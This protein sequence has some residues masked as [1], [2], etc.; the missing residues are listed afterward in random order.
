M[1]PLR[2]IKIPEK[3]PT[4]IEGIEHITQGGFTKGRTTLVVGTS[5]S[6]KTL[7]SLEFLYRGIT[8]FQQKAVFVTIEEEVEDII[9]N[10]KNLGWDLDTLEQ[11]GQLKFVDASP[12]ESPLVEVGNYNL[13]GLMVQIES[14]IEEVSANLVVVDSIGSLFEQF[15]NQKTIRREI[16]RL[17][18][19]LKRL[20]CTSLITA[21][22]LEEYG[23]ISRYGIEEFVSDNVVVLRSVLE[24]EKIRRTIQILKMR[25]HAHAKGEFPFIIAETGFAI[26]PLSARELQQSSSME[27]VGSG[28]ATVDEMTSGGLFRD[29]I[30]L[31]SGPTGS[32]KTLMC[33][34]FITEACQQGEKVLLLAYE[35]SPQQLRRNAQSW[36]VDFNK[37]ES[38]GLLKIISLY[39]ESMGLEEHLLLLQREVH[40]FHP[41]RFVMDS[42]SAMER[43]AT[44][45]NFREFVIGMTSFMKQEEVCCLLTCTTPKL[46]GGESITEAHISTI[47]DIIVLLRYV[48]IQGSLRRGIAVIKMRGSQHDKDIHEFTIDSQGLHVGEPFKE[49]QNI[50]LGT[51]S[52]ST[53][54]D[55]QRL[56]MMFSEGGLDEQ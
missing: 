9:G 40:S 38:E 13:E 11:A 6:G 2:Q 15:S 54:P 31:V 17:T 12:K 8:R 27:R 52:M 18:K 5:G 43:V 4:G 26:L 20:G 30:M 14:A 51:P 22:R 53:M 10:V 44:I 1:E 41:R 50:L 55:T 3:L 34:T 21:E 49:A 16:L 56:E 23:T 28:N 35:E 36:N 46:A 48:E 32:G 25:G 19:L 7:L 45:K 42:V 47:T 37:W 39:P 24:E 29:S 33:A